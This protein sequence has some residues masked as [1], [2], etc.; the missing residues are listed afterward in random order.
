MEPMLAWQ[1]GWH[2]VSGPVLVADGASIHDGL[3]KT[4]V[5]LVT[6]MHLMVGFHDAKGDKHAC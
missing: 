3:F 4:W 2:L 5:L 6:V 1:Q